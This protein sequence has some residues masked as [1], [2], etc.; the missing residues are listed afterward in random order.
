M[1]QGCGRAN[2]RTCELAVFLDPPGH[3][4]INDAAML[5]STPSRRGTEDAVL[6]TY[7]RALRSVVSPKSTFVPRT[8][9]LLR[10][11]DSMSILQYL[12]LIDAA[13]LAT[14]CLYFRGTHLMKIVVDGVLN[15]DFLMDPRDITS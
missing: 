13:S 14:T 4:N 12:F 5:R 6:R 7:K 1:L 11:N 2:V 8:L 15:F 10:K 9:R 3:T